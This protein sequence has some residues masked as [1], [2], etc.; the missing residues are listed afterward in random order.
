VRF[1]AGVYIED[2]IPTPALSSTLQAPVFGKELERAQFDPPS[3][4]VPKEDSKPSLYSSGHV[5]NVAVGNSALLNP[6]LTDSS[7]L[8]DLRS[9]D[10]VFEARAKQAAK[11]MVTV[12]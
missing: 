7:Q 2:V 1:K 8:P 12:T 9:I 3:I 10:A 6:P 11:S 5:L 4:H